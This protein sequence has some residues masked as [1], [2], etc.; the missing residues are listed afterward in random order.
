MR[1]TGCLNSKPPPTTPWTS[2]PGVAPKT[3]QKVSWFYWLPCTNTLSPR[4]PS[5]L[6]VPEVLAKG[7]EF[8]GN[9]YFNYSLTQY[10]TAY[11]PSP[12]LFFE[13]PKNTFLNKKIMVLISDG[14]SERGSHV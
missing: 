12:P 13:L 3:L 1:H 4:P 5:I 11:S 7:Q 8:L 2:F 6:Y 14:K 10:Q 9:Q